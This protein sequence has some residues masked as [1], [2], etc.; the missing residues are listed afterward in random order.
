MPLGDAVVNVGALQHLVQDLLQGTVV[1]RI[2]L[3]RLGQL[4]LFTIH[5]SPTLQP[6]PLYREG[7]KHRTNYQK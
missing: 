7:G 1:G 6:L 5:K 3:Q 4:D 2:N